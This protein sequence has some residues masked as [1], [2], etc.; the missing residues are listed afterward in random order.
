MTLN[1]S[2]GAN[3]SSAS[4]RITI[5][6]SASGNLILGGNINFT[7]EAF[8]ANITGPGSITQNT[9]IVVTANW[10]SLR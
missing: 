3:N 10:I 1:S 4:V 7:N 8:Y 9:G 5:S 6:N 2:Q